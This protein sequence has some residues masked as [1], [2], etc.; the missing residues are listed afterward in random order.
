MNDVEQR[1]AAREFVARYEN[2]SETTSSEKQID[3]KFWNDLLGKVFGV[4]DVSDFIAYQKPVKLK[5]T[6]WI[7]GYIKSTEV[8]IEQKSKGVDLLKPIK[9]SDGSFLTPYEQAKRYAN[10]LPYSER[11]RWIITC[12]FEKFLVYD[13]NCPQDEPQEILLKDLE[14]DYHRLSFLVN[15]NA[16]VQIEQRVS[17]EAGKIIGKIYNALLKQ[18]NDSNTEGTL[19]SLNVLCVRLVFCLYAEDA[20][21]FG[22]RNMFLDYLREFDARKMRGALIELFKVLDTKEED[23]DPYLD[24]QLAAFPYVNGGLFTDDSIAIPQFTD[25]IRDLLLEKASSDFNWSLISPTIFGA[26][27][28]STLN[29]VTRRSSGMHYTSVENI[30]KVIDP[31]FL[32]DLANEL[33]KI[34]EIKVKKNRRNALLQYQEKLGNLKFLDPACG[35]GN[36]LTETYLC[37]RRLENEVL[38]ELY[39]GEI[40]LGDLVDVIKVTIDQFYGIEINDFAV[41][42]ARTAM[43]IAESQMVKETEDIV[44]KYFEYLPLKSNAY[45]IEDNALRIDWNDVVP[46]A[47]LNY[48]I[49]NPPFIGYSLQTKEQKADIL[50]VYI[51]ENG[52]SYKTAGKLDYVAGWY[53]KAASLM[54]GTNIRTAFVS[55]N[56]IT[57]GEQVAGVWKPLYERFGIHIDFAWRTFKWESEATMKAAV[58]VVIVG[59]S[60]INKNIERVLF[61]NDDVVENV[62]TISPYLIDAPVVFVESNKSSLSDV[63]EMVYGNKP[64]DG[65]HLFLDVDERNAIVETDKIASKYI[66]QIYGA[67][68][69]INNKLR[70]CLWLVD[71]S[72]LD[73]RSS[74]FL[75]DRV[76]KVRA[77]RMESSKQATKN[78]ADSSTLF[79]E[80]RQPNSDYIIVPCHSSENRNYIPIGFERPE[81]IVTNAVQIIPNADLYHF[82]IMTSNVH[83]AWMRVVAGRLKSDYRYSKDIVYN[84]FPWCNPTEAQRAKIEKTA[85]GILDARALYS[86]NSFA[87]LYDETTMPIKLRKAH[88]DNDRAVMEAYGFKK[89]MTESEIVAKLMKMYQELVESKK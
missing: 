54:K 46:K 50:S 21:L 14:T 1:L 2:I 70:Y 48:I 80:I 5:N 84:N 49:S 88:I 82:G 18:Y 76:A 29:P 35:S 65:G 9:Q 86:D 30:H 28:E 81:V 55:T 19:K 7:D 8:L 6:C 64:T 59:F 62:K 3:Q 25:E 60:C 16:R 45:I 53:F 17:I 77:F 74:A 51:D 72:P 27:F 68:E 75:S 79:Q 42:V 44:H 15:P 87:D 71:A 89:N 11:V 39:N 31:L 10:E 40:V 43:W 85:Q 66:K 61:V 12:N 33:D 58:H 38:R 36:F 56:S 47:E 37:L 13:R 23:R 41:A 4:Q 32:T 22:E 26:L 57:Q 83:N 20:G 24:E 78:S 73:I 67:T 52:K 63:P 34:R 69:F